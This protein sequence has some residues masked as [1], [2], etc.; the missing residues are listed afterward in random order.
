M[1]GG[2]ALCRIHELWILGRTTASHR[3][4]YV[5]KFDDFFLSSRERRTRKFS[6]A[7]NSD[8]MNG[9]RFNFYEIDQIYVDFSV[10]QAT[11]AEFM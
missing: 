5:E 9:W 3:K 4:I 1:T 11:I 10:G 2:A 7:V 6:G 8:T